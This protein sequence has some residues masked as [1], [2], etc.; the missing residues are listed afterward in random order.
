MEIKSYRPFMAPSKESRKFLILSF[1]SRNP[2]ISLIHQLLGSCF[3]HLA[4]FLLCLSSPKWEWFLDIFHHKFLQSF[5][6]QEGGWFSSRNTKEARKN[7][8]HGLATHGRHRMQKFTGQGSPAVP[9]LTARTVE[10]TL[11]QR[12]ASRGGAE[13]PSAPPGRTT[14]ETARLNTEA[15]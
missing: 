8:T 9:P 7:D 13:L 14:S 6:R 4:F 12:S 5:W 11:T 1:F 2:I 3:A 15:G 10:G